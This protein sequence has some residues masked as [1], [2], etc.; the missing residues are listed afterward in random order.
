MSSFENSTTH[1]PAKEVNSEFTQTLLLSRS[2]TTRNEFVGSF[3]TLHHFSVGHAE[4]Y[5]DRLPRVGTRLTAIAANTDNHDQLSTEPPSTSMNMGQEHILIAT[6]FDCR[7]WTQG[8][9]YAFTETPNVSLEYEIARNIFSNLRAILL[10][11]SI[12]YV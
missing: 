8:S 6:Y 12:F 10:C 2:P 3:N 9:S 5:A 7:L 1:A 11:I 4:V